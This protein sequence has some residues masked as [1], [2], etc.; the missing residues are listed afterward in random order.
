M[1]IEIYIVCNDPAQWRKDLLAA[2]IGTEIVYI[3]KQSA[4]LYGSSPWQHRFKKTAED[5]LENHW[6]AVYNTAS[7]SCGDIENETG[8]AV[9][10]TIDVVE[11]LD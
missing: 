10:R 3:W 6:N 9:V 4:S 5:R 2:P 11:E 1:S 8:W 7:F